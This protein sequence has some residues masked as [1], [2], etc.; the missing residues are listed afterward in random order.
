MFAIGP[1]PAAGRATELIS[2]M[3]TTVWC[4]FKAS[5]YKNA[6]HLRNSGT[7]LALRLAV[8]GSYKCRRI[9]GTCGFSVDAG[10]E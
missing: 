2:T 4:G 9:Y 1:E 5:S 7:N 6:S 3:Q 8:S 10:C